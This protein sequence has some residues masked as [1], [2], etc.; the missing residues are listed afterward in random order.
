MGVIIKFEKTSP[1]KFSRRI[2][3][4]VC[5]ASEITAHILLSILKKL[6]AWDIDSINYPLYK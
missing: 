6:F 2:L 1:L 4:Y 3:I 5:L